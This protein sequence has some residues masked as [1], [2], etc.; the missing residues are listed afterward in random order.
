[1]VQKRTINLATGLPA[2]VNSDDPKELRRVINR[3]LEVIR[4]WNG[5]QGDPGDRL[6]THREQ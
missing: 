3:L 6:V 2:S 5:E 1:M 4:V